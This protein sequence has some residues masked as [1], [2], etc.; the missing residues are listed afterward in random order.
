MSVNTLATV[1][2]GF[3]DTHAHYNDPR[4][5]ETFGDVD[6]WIKHLLDENVAYI[7]NAATDT[8]KQLQ[9]ACLLPKNLLLCMQP[10]AFIP[11]TQVHKSN[12]CKKSFRVSNNCLHIPKPWRWEKSDWIITMTTPRAICNG[13]G[14]MHKLPSLVRCAKHACG[15]SRPGS[16][17]RY[18]GHA[19]GTQR[20]ARCD[21]LVFRKRGN[22][23]STVAPR[24]LHLVFRR[25]YVQKCCKAIGCGT[26][27]SV[28]PYA[29]RNRLPISIPRPYARQ[30]QSQRLSFLHRRR[31]C[32]NQANRRTNRHADNKREC[33][34]M[35]WY[36][37]EQQL[38]L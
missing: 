31:H 7:L 16:A 17:R 22:G 12:R 2:D 10:S 3:F 27:C 4:M 35:L 20:C 9:S 34:S 5:R 18:D 30:M 25:G 29:D 26:I 32:T 21:A 1:R 11:Q 6:A 38:I 23:K 13:N 33:V 24:F 37:T 19:L 36:H 15:D 14:L 8:R 28:V